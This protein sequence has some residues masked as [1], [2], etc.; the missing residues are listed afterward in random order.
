MRL[1]CLAAQSVSQCLSESLNSTAV[2][3]GSPELGEDA[4]SMSLD[5]RE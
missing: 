1:A 3:D 5:V 2:I 4:S